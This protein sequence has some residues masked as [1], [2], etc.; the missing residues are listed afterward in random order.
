MVLVVVKDCDK[1]RKE[2]IYVFFSI[3]VLPV[4]ESKSRKLLKQ[5]AFLE[6]I[7]LLGLLIIAFCVLLYELKQ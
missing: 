2:S 7:H 5:L 3:K 1:L 4:L 6:E